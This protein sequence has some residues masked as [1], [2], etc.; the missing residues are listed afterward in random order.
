MLSG[1]PVSR[2]FVVLLTIDGEEVARSPTTSDGSFS[3]LA[4]TEGIYRLRSER[5]GYRAWESNSITISSGSD[6]RHIISVTS[7]PTQLSTVVILGE[8]RCGDMR[9]DSQFATI[10]EEARK[11]LSAA[12]WTGRQGY[13]TPIH[14]YELIRSK[15]NNRI[16]SERFW[17]ETAISLQPFVAVDPTVLL[18]YGFIEYT[19]GNYQYYGPDANVLLHDSFHGQHCFRFTEDRVDGRRLI[20]LEFEPHPDQTLSDIAGTLWLDAETSE[21]RSLEWRYVNPPFK[22][23]D[24]SFGGS[25]TFTPLPSGEW[26]ISEWRIR[27]PSYGKHQP[28]VDD[29]LFAIGADP[30]S[31]VVED[32]LG[33]GEVGGKVIQMTNQDRDV[34]YRAPRM[35]YVH[36]TLTDGTIVGNSEEQTIVVEGTEYRTVTDSSGDYELHTLLDDTYNLTTARFDSL[37]YQPQESRVRLSRGDSTRIDLDGPSLKEIY[38]YHCSENENLRNVRALVGIVRESLSGR[39]VK[40]VQVSGSWFTTEVTPGENP[41]RVRDR[42]KSDSEGRFALCHLPVGR[43]IDIEASSRHFQFQ[44]IAIL[45]GENILR[46]E[47]GYGSTQSVTFGPI[48]KLDLTMEAK[49]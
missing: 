18:K 29:R 12:S 35:S 13:D 9:G 36:G 38:V 26:I 11:A 19:D 21:L 22:I 32:Y 49:R 39:P 28:S 4:P 1:S 3:L 10:W 45:F 7:L 30:S 16:L 37:G 14:R 5:I 46:V 33:P 23:E 6:N 42:S 27:V 15:R 41:D 8:N 43:I 24:E 44:P 34:I 31:L 25:L 48:A 47:G 2:G 17:N 20:G 40:D